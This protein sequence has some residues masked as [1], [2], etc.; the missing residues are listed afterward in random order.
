MPLYQEALNRTLHSS[1]ALFP[2]FASAR[3]RLTLLASL[4]LLIILPASLYAQEKGSQNEDEVLR[5]RTDLVIVPFIVKDARGRRVPGLKPTDFSVRDNGS[6]VRLEY[7]GEGTERVALAFALDASGSVRELL[8]RQRETAMAL[9]SRFGRE[10]RVAVL[11]FSE[12]P[13]LIVPFTTEASR[14]LA[15][16]EF[17]PAGNRRTAIF[18]AAV[19]A[20]HAFDARG[21]APVERRIVILISDGLD[22]A[23]RMSASAAINEARTRDVSFYVIHLPLFA[24]RDGRLAPRPPAKGF[25]PLA[26]ETG[27]KYFIIGDAK[28]A[29]DPRAALDLAPVFRAIEDDLKGQYVVGYYPDRTAH[30]ELY[31]RIEVNVTS[32]DKHKL[33]VQTLHEEYT[34]KQ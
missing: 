28:S 4:L 16:F 33:H 5:V 32:T 13:Q 19:A 7:F 23:S 2:L 22:T 18:D 20:V 34:L 14:A 24:P 29:L 3:F 26:E 30:D 9:F 10:S 31:H 27:G 21:G 12:T 8:V 17:P 25:R 6:A 15:G 11:Q 1:S